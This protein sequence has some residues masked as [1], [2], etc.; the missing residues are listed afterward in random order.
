MTE[1]RPSVAEP[2]PEPAARALCSLRLPVLP[3]SHPTS[4]GSPRVRRH[5]VQGQALLCTGVV[6]DFRAQPH[7]GEPPEA[8]RQK[9]QPRQRTEEGW[10]DNSQAQQG[11]GQGA[12][13]TPQ[14]RGGSKAS[15]WASPCC[16][17][18]WGQWGARRPSARDLI[19]AP[20]SSLAQADTS[21]G[22]SEDSPPSPRHA[23]PQLTLHLSPVPSSPRPYPSH[24]AGPMHLTP[25]VIHP[26][27]CPC[28]GDLCQGLQ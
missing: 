3:H 20:A 28:R 19:T 11:R 4:P 7:P 8:S 12:I 10:G 24:A 5:L 21:V 9:G 27:E 14:P 13:L 17:F 23:E 1:P 22:G 2:G 16:D 26:R 6:G 25:E 18:S 15:S